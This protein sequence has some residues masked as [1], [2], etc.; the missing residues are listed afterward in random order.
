MINQLLQLEQ[1][2][3]VCLD[4]SG[5]PLMIDVARSPILIRMVRHQ[6]LPAHQLTNSYSH[7]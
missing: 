2:L 5:C 4:T 3:F 1:L 6:Q 7:V